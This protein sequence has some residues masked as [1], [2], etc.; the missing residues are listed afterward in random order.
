M[1]GYSNFETWAALVHLQATEGE[2]LKTKDMSA[3]QLRE[4][5]EGNA[6]ELAEGL[7]KELLRAALDNINYAELAEAIQDEGQA[8]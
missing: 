1:N 8:Q 4:Y 5:I 6:P 2:Y 7:Y 3:D